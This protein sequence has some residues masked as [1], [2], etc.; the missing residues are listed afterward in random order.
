MLLM[1]IH[2]GGSKHTKGTE[3]M[4]VRLLRLVLRSM[5]R[6]RRRM[7]W[8]KVRLMSRS[9]RRRRSRSWSVKTY[10]IML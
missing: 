10:G 3:I 5:L 4:P 7:M 1:G 9:L 2:L 8:R 6:T